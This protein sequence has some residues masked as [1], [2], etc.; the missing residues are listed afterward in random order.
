[1]TRGK[2]AAAV[3]AGPVE[4]PWDLP[5]G[6]RWE[7]L[8]DLGE[9]SSGGTPSAKVAAY[10]GGNIPWLNS[11]ELN[12]GI[13]RSAGKS[14]T[15][16][17][18]DNSAVKLLPVDTLLVAM[19]GATIGKAAITEFEC[20]TNQA[21]AA[22]RPHA[23]YNVRFLLHYVIS[24]RDLLRKL[25]QGG[26]QPNISQA[27]L[28]DY[29]CPVPPRPVQDIVVARIDALFAE[30]E[31]G[32]A[33]LADARSGVETYRKSLLKAAVTGE[34]T[35]DWRRDNPPQQS[36]EQLLERLLNDV[37]VTRNAGN[38]KR[39]SK[40]Q[41]VEFAPDVQDLMW[42][43]PSHWQWVPLGSIAFVTKLAGFEYTKYVQYADDGDLPV[44]KAENAGLHG[45]KPTNYSRVHSD[46]VEELTR[47]KLTGG[48]LLMVFVG[49]GTGNV[50]TVP[51]NEEYFLGPNI[52]MMRLE[53]ENIEPR[54]V[55]LFLRSLGGKALA[56]AFAKA[57]AQP[58]LSMG[59]IRQIP[60]AIPPIA[61]QRE[62]L[63]RLEQ[64]IRR[65]E[66]AGQ[67]VTSV[68]YNAE[69]LRQ[70]ILAAAFRGDLTP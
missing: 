24:Q 5:D 68:Q 27:L 63:S 61:E 35:A 44:L 17:G 58:S 30:I 57:V 13:V 41:P 32:E 49:A 54:Y 4:G 64:A 51:N 34:L 48:E 21:I 18:Y 19:Y 56:M 38:A 10:Y 52:A 66:D 26:A 43:I 37:E 12:D 28:K 9:W 47:S 22:C 42:A 46:A 14:I 40:L 70:S 23:E 11:G 33:A 60:I 67:L 1:M 50:A 65:G 45:F 6:W 39:R 15:Q 3:D 29:L 20:T 59:T 16:A 53:T 36:R 55:E 31:A 7:R 25:G 2:K 62:A 8:G 69:T